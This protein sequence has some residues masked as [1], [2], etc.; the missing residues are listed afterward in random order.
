MVGQSEFA[1]SDAQRPMAVRLASCHRPDGDI[2][3]R[4]VSL[5]PSMGDLT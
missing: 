5:G 2:R 3:Y 1:P 4:D